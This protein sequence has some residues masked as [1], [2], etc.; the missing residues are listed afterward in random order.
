[1]NALLGSYVALTLLVR[2]KRRDIS[3]ARRSA[4]LVLAALSLS[5]GCWACECNHSPVYAY[6]ILNIIIS[7]TSSRLYSAPQD[8]PAMELFVG[9]DSGFAMLSLCIP[10]LIILGT[11]MIFEPRLLHHPGRGSLW[12]YVVCGP[13]V[14]LSGQ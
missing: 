5:L 11:F 14:G 3:M 9:F 10:T 12:F 7:V 4:V 2:L 6:D 13:A 1:M 8:D